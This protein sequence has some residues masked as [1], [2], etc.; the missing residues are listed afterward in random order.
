VSIPFFF[1]FLYHHCRYDVLIDQN[2]RP[3]LIEVNASPSLA[4]DNAL[5]VRVK[6]A[7]IRDLIELLDV[8]Q[9]DRAV[10]LRVLKRRLK[11]MA[12]TKSIMSKNAGRGD[13][14][15]ETDLRDILGS[16]Y[17]PREYGEMPKK[18]GGYEMLCPNTPLYDHII[19]IKSKIMKPL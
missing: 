3:W 10:L 14:D 7:A 15:L 16:D 6:N 2:L 13:P 17:Y 18:M 19:K 12:R 9:Y 11:E 5:D 4:R 1:L 8:P